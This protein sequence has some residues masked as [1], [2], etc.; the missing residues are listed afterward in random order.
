[1]P[2]QMYDIFL[3]YARKIRT[4]SHIIWTYL[5]TSGQ[6]WTMVSATVVT[7]HRNSK[8]GKFRLPLE[9]KFAAL[10]GKQKDPLTATTIAPLC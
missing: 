8:A 5:D 4:I 9:G 6:K 3:D 7:L 2:L 10:K 1:M